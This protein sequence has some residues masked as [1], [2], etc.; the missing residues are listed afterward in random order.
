MDNLT[1]PLLLVALIGLGLT[2]AV[3]LLFIN[4][5]EKDES[6]YAE[7]E[8]LSRSGYTIYINGSAVDFDKIVIS[9]YPI[10]KIH[11]NDERKE[12]YISAGTENE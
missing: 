4:Y 2:I 6:Y 9:D 1:T 7:I 8:N 10:K 11:I 3:I 5:P 12:I